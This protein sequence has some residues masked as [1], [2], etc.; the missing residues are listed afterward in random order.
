[1][2]RP[3]RP[4]TLNFG[5]GHGGGPGGPPLDRINPPHIREHSH[6][7]PSKGP[8]ILG[9]PPVV[10]PNSPNSSHNSATP[11]PTPPPSH[12]HRSQSQGES[13][14]PALYDPFGFKPRL[15]PQDMLS[16]KWAYQARH[17][18]RAQQALIAAQG[19]VLRIEQDLVWTEREMFEKERRMAEA[20]ELPEEDDVGGEGVMVEKS[21]KGGKPNRQTQPPRP[22]NANAPGRKYGGDMYMPGQFPSPT[23]N[24]PPGGGPNEKMSKSLVPVSSK[25]NVEGGPSAGAAGGK[26]KPLPLRIGSGGH[27][28]SSGGPH[29]RHSY[30]PG[31][32]P[33]RSN[34]MTS[35]SSHDS[36]AKAV[37]A[38]ERER[39]QHAK[40]RQ[41]YEK[42]Y[43]SRSSSRGHKFEEMRKTL[44]GDFGSPAS[45]DEEEE[46]EGYGE[47][48]DRYYPGQ[49]TEA[50]NSSKKEKRRPDMLN[51]KSGGGGG[52]NGGG[53]GGGGGGGYVDKWVQGSGGGGGGGGGGR[54]GNRW[55]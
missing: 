23:G 26:N 16:Q 12:G 54:S 6:P 48:Y 35:D 17:L 52:G 1:M 34:S 44:G 36:D 37:H 47:R 10:A 51:M 3:P 24:G 55:L 45:E 14:P 41:E 28:G 7:G 22:A 38:A 21:E 19:E 20:G 18:I 4:L 27:G 25:E 8:P 33:I 42:I 11:M 49:Y 2:P 32:P 9:G 29:M 13:G 43:G 31:M 30:H 50:L 53:G 46:D 40:Y 5:P 39:M 15:P